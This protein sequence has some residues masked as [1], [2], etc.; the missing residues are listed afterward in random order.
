MK[1][2]LCFLLYFMGTL[3]VGYGQ[4]IKSIAHPKDPEQDFVKKSG[5]NFLLNGKPYY[6][7]G[8]NYWQGPL[9]SIRSFGKGGRHRVQ[10]ELKFLADHN[11]TNLRIVWAPKVAELLT[12]RTVSVPPCNRKKVSS[13]PMRLTGWITC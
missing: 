3:S 1:K 4:Q 11:V 8:T 9:L 7:I 5:I 12:G 2:K 6:Y 10:R 13:A